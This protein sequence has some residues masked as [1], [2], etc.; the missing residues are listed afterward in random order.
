MQPIDRQFRFTLDFCI[1]W[2]I[3][4]MPSYLLL[5]HA[6]IWK[7]T[8]D[9]YLFLMFVSLFATFLIYGPVL[10]MRQ[11]ICS[12]SRGWFMAR[13]LLSI[14]LVTI[15]FF[16]GLYISG[17]GKDVSSIWGFVAAGIATFYLHW[18]TDEK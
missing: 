10:L 6:D 15:L 18:R 1:V 13:V 4:V 2:L 3:L 7:A 9:N 12:G 5:R 11:I 8:W 16:V 14:L 17:H